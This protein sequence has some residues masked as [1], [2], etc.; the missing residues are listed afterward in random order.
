LGEARITDATSAQ[1]A[2]RRHLEAHYGA[3]KVKN[4]T[5]TR[6]WFSPGSSMEVWEVE[7]DVEIQMGF[8]RRDV[9]HF[10]YQIEAT[11]GRVVG[12]EG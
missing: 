5:F 3:A 6:C 10:K 11:Q 8:L 1:S 12:F 9:R 2:A 7:G 4:V